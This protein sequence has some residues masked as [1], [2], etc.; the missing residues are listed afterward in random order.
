VL[1]ASSF[2]VRADPLLMFLLSVAKEIATLPPAAAAPQALPETY[3]GTTVE[4]VRL[5][6]LIDESFVY[7]SSA[8][9]TEV[10]EALNAELLK[11]QNAA[12]R[13]PMLEQFAQ[14]ALEVR[15]AQQ[16]LEQLSTLEK[17]V[18]ASEFQKEV[19]SLSPEDVLQVR[20]AIEKNVLPVPSDL[21]RLLLAAFD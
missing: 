5:R 8:Q 19:K 21:N 2:P 16:R 9:R 13:G 20:Q 1:L 17:Q 12:I 4:P 3:P 14:R 7:L 6:A 10:F 18:L 11:P 15:A